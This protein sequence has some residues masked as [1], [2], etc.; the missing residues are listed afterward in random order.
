MAI[1]LIYSDW[2]QGQWWKQSTVFETKMDYFHTFGGNMDDFV[3]LLRK[4]RYMLDN[5]SKNLSWILITGWHSLWDLTA[6]NLGWID[7]RM[8]SDSSKENPVSQIIVYNSFKLQI[9][10]FLSE[11]WFDSSDAGSEWDWSLQ[12]RSEGSGAGLAWDSLINSSGAEVCTALSVWWIDHAHWSA[13]GCPG[14]F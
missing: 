11:T 7:A 13:R 8:T 2:T 12:T 10:G 14:L 9:C 4:A 3:C 6:L 5:N 1:I